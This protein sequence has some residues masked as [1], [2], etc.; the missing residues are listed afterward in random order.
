MQ[1]TVDMFVNE[2]RH[3]IALETLREMLIFFK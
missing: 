2:H 1:D 3:A